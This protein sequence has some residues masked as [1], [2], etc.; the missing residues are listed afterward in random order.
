MNVSVS[1]I[2]TSLLA[3]LDAKKREVI[4]GRYGLRDGEQKTLA[5]LGSKYAVT[6]E[7]IRQIE[8]GAFE[9]LQAVAGKS[10]E[11]GQF[12]NLVK[13]H[14]KNIGGVRREVLLL[15]DL[16]AMIG[17]PNTANLSSKVKLILEVAGEPKFCSDGREF[18]S[19]WYL[20]EED[21]KKATTLVAKLANWLNGRKDQETISHEKVD[22][23]FNEAIKPHNLKD[24]VAL[25]YVSMSK[26][27]HV[28]HFGDFGLSEWPSV[29]PRTVRDWVY[30]VLKKNSK[31]AHF[32]DIAVMI[33]KVRKDSKVAHPQT[34]HNELIKDQRFILVGRGMYGLKEFGLMPGT[35]RE[36]MSRLLKQHGPLTPKELLGLVLKERLLKKN[37]ILIN[38]QNKKYFKRL[39]DGRYTLH[40]V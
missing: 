33:N 19:Y 37:T 38:L 9:D 17:D 5:E 8:A 40:L 15:S 25:N 3:G 29:N 2:I 10:A 13:T 27:F 1:K 23:F 30:L 28:N 39:E 18:H 24:L 21:R 32:E 20:N 31:P 7:R 22:S 6:R 26:L 16:R 36:V 11:I 4:E 12:V 14:I 34:V 35:A